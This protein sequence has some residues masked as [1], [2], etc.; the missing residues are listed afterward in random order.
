[1]YNIYD[2]IIYYN[3]VKHFKQ[4]I[5]TITYTLCSYNIKQQKKQQ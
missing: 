2:E 1:M 3:K 4:Y 5:L